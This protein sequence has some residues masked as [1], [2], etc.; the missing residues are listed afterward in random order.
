MLRAICTRTRSF[1]A[2]QRGA[3]S[4]GHLV[5]HGSGWLKSREYQIL[6]FSGGAH[7][8]GPGRWKLRRTRLTDE[9]TSSDEPGSNLGNVLV[10]VAGKLHAYSVIFFIQRCTGCVS[11]LAIHGSEWL[12]SRE[13]Q[14]FIIQRWCPPRWPGEVEAP[15]D[16]L[17][18]RVDFFR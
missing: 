9:P 17:D 1:L 3:G 5:M 16:L 2:E 11:R 15:T 18:G 6:L 10:G 8:D 4:V 14:I 13:F 7:R 12:K